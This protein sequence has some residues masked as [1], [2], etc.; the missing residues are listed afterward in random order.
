MV[1]VIPGMLV[2]KLEQDQGAPLPARLVMYPDPVD[3]GE[4]GY[5]NERRQYV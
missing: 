5:H 4:H 3:I 2:M 1:T